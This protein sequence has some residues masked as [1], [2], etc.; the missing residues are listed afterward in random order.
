M[1]GLAASFAACAA[2]FSL[3]AMFRVCHD[4]CSV[5]GFGFSFLCDSRLWGVVVDAMSPLSAFVYN[6]SEGTSSEEVR[7]YHVRTQNV[8]IP[9]AKVPTAPRP[10]ISSRLTSLGKSVVGLPGRTPADGSLA[11]AGA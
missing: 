8:L 4:F 1:P 7:A 5:F 9:S 10:A 2:C 3:R 6:G 11:V